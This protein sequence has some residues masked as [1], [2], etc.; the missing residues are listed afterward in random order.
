MTPARVDLRCAVKCS[1]LHWRRLPIRNVRW[2]EERRDRCGRVRSEITLPSYRKGRKPA[3]TGRT[4]PTDPLTR[5]ELLDVMECCED[6]VTG[7]RNLALIVLLWRS[8]L[9]ISE[10]LALQMGDLNQD[11]GTVTV[12]CGKGGKYRVVG[13]DQMSWWL[14]TPWL[15][16]REGFPG[17]AV[18]PV[19]S[20]PS[21]G[22]AIGDPYV[23]TSFKR[24]AERAGVS[25]RF[26]PHQLRHQYACELV[27]EG[28]PLLHI[29]RSLGHSSLATTAT[30]LAGIAPQET[31][32]VMAAREW[33]A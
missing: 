27:R 24:Y 17:S 8:G 12:K 3:N 7:R 13:M 30:Y 23:R 2:L 4:F 18:F 11:R 32:D 5:E 19:T 6:T 20:G 25:R 10:A 31:I 29:S 9:R 15:A 1:A 16:E 22:L 26:A 33:P 28:V 21:A 14:L